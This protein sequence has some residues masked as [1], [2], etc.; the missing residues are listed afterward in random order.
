MASYDF[1][2]TTQPMADQMHRVAR[3]VET[4]GGAVTAMQAAVIATEQEAADRVCASIDSGFYMLVRSKIS[5]RIS[6]F[7]S[8]M[9]S[10]AGSMMETA[11]AIDHTR[12]QMTSDF[13]HIKERYVKLFAN[14]DR[15]LAERVRE[16]DRPAM[17]LARRRKELLTD[18]LC[19]EAPSVF[20]LSSDTLGVA[21]KAAGARLKVGASESISSLRE[22]AYRKLEYERSTRDMI[23]PPMNA[24]PWFFCVPVVYAEQESLTMPGTYVLDVEMPQGL[25]ATTRAAIGN[26]VADKRQTLPTTDAQDVQSIKRLFIQRM[27]TENVDGRVGATMIQL[28]D[29]S[30]SMAGAGG[31]GAVP[32]GVQQVPQPGVGDM[33]ANGAWPQGGAS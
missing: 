1:T 16:L 32:Y 25:S 21:T 8:T 5:Q 10:R 27:N 9:R 3:N 31:A 20:Y 22:G 19:R 6:Q 26:A 17:D 33:P 14:L 23:E 13:N 29:A 18:L 30:F 12:Q 7:S 2:I 28:F 15:N 24:E 4:V 11:Q